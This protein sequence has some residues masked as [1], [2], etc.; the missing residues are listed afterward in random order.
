MFK[1]LALLFVLLAMHCFTAVA[2]RAQ[3]T[4]FVYQGTLKDGANPANGS[5]DFEFRLFDASSSGTQVG[6]LLTRSSVPVAS[7]IFSVSLDFGSV[8]P[9]SER[10]LEVRA[11]NAGGTSFTPLNPRQKL[12]SSPYSVKSLTSDNALQLGGVAANQYV[13]T[14]DPRMTDARN[15]LAN[16]PNYIQNT[17]VQQAASNFNISGNGTAAGTLSGGI[18]NAGSQFNLN[19]SRVLF[20]GSTGISVGINAGIGSNAAFFG[21]DAGIVNTGPANTFLGYHAGDDNTSGGNNTFVGFVAGQ[22]TITGGSNSFVGANAGEFNTGSDNVAIGANA[23]GPVNAGDGNTFLGARTGSS[24]GL[25]NATAVGYRATVTQSNSLVLGSINGGFAE[26]TNVG[27]GTTAPARRLHVSSGSSGATSLGSSDFV[28]E[29]DASAFQHFLTPDDIES[30]I[31]FGDPSASIGG[32]IIFNNA[33]ANNG[34]QF[35]SGGNTTRMTLDGAG[36]LGIGTVAPLNKLD[37][38]GTIGVTSL[39]GAGATHLC[40]NALNQISTC[41]AQRPEIAGEALNG[42]VRELQTEIAALRKAKAEQQEQI[43]KQQRQIEILTRLVCSQVSEPTICR[44]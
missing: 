2:I 21:R 36:N 24:N 23:G 10:F 9:G 7:G 27:I 11:R 35:R 20:A 8:F 44:P 14:T 13:V 34:I 26:D 33:V 32:G 28:I 25:T 16:S 40:R 19:N 38:L 30:G 31:L 17:G 3:S 6:S 42:S 18:V 29:D 1:A 43:D 22:N 12:T 4:E 41:T 37:V 5:Y 15:P 39:G